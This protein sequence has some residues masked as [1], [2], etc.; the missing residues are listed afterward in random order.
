[1]VVELAGRLEADLQ[2]RIPI[3]SFRQ[4]VTIA[5]LAAEVVSRLPD[6][7]AGAEPGGVLV[8]IQ[9]LGGRPPVFLVTAGYGDLLSFQRLAQAL[10]EDQPFYGLQPPAAAKE[11]EELASEYAAAVRTVQPAGPYFLGGFCSGGIVAHAVAR[12]LVEDGA[13][14]RRLLLL[15]SPWVYSA[16]D[17]AAYRLLKGLVGGRLRSPGGNRLRQ[18]IWALCSDRGL[19]L[20]LRLITGYVPKSYVGPISLFLAKR[21]FVRFTHA[22]IAWR[23]VA[24]GSQE[25]TLVPG[26]HDNFL[27]GT[28]VQSLAAG[29]RARLEQAAEHPAPG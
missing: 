15:D 10:G 19:D 9:P 22:P 2:A 17:H 26:D 20:H 1:M 4:G 27:R 23:R 21:S 6:A 24:R 8:P 16:L 13:E 18:I 28:R 29:L 12:R 7:E 3:S 5:R 11:L 25:V 14:V